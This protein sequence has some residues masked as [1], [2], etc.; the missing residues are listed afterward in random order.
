MIAVWLVT[1]RRFAVAHALE[2]Q[3]DALHLSIDDAERAWALEAIGDDHEGAF[4][5]DD[6]IP[7]WES[8]LAALQNNPDARQSRIRL[9]VKCATMAGIRW[10]GFKVVPPTRQVDDYIDAGLSAG[11]EARDRGWLLALRAYCNTRKGGSRE[12]DVVPMAERSRGG[13]AA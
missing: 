12:I 11:P 1:R 13:R 3:Q 10:G 4:H 6:A 7:A 2:L 8:A 9:L 5:G